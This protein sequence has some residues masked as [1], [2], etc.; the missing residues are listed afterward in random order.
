MRYAFRTVVPILVFFCSVVFLPSPLR[1]QHGG[2]GGG[3]GG[4]RGAGVATGH[5]GSRSA[6]GGGLFGHGRVS[7]RALAGEGRLGTTGRGY[8]S[9]RAS[10]LPALAQGHG[11]VYRDRAHDGPGHPDIGIAH[12]HRRIS[13]Q[14]YA[15]GVHHGLGVGITLGYL[16]F[17]NPWNR[18]AYPYYDRYPYYRD[19]YPPDPLLNRG[20]PGPQA[21]SVPADTLAASANRVAVP[22]PTGRDSLVVERVPLAEERAP[23]I[24]RVTWQERDQRAE[25]VALFLADSTQVV[26]AVQTLRVPPFTAFFEPPTGTA[27]AGMTVVWPNGSKSTRLV[28]LTASSRF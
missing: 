15:F 7:G 18:Y 3:H 11:P 16:P 5:G 28:I 20:D 14:H 19:G 26:L 17:F 1:A 24:L 12:D 9:P 8:L 2:H 10:R 4:H 25:E 13:L 21:D 6:H 27:F 23:P 22:G